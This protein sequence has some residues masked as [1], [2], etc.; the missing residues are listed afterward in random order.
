MPR[1]HK[2]SCAMFAE[3]VGMAFIRWDKFDAV[4]FDAV[5]LYHN[6][7]VLLKNKW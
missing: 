6:K 4:F 7:S 2:H 1:L 5:L 3:L